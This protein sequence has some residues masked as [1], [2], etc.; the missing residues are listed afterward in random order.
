MNLLQDLKFCIWNI[1]YWIDENINH[2]IFERIFTL[3]PMV[4]DDKFD[5]GYWLWFRT[6]RA[7]CN[8]VM[9]VLVD[10]HWDKS[11]QQFR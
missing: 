11:S 10:K 1:L 8:F 9:F 3:F 7:F 5:F 4:D 6:S 2:A